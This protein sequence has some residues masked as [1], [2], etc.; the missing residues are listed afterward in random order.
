MTYYSHLVDVPAP[1]EVYD[2]THAE[3]QRRTAG[4]ASPASPFTCADPPTADSRSSRSA[5]SQA[6]YQRADWEL[7]APILASHAQPT[8]NGPDEIT[9]AQIEEFLLRGLVVPHSSIVA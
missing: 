8:A 9:T 6:D 4:P 3:L 5:A 1:A 2:A 7:I